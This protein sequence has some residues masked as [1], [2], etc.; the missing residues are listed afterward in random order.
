MSR[1]KVSSLLVVPFSLLFSACGGPTPTVISGTLLGHDGEPMMAAA[2]RVSRW[3]TRDQRDSTDPGAVFQEVDNGSFTIETFETGLL[4]VRFVGAYH[5]DHDVALYADTP[6]STELDVRLGT[7]EYPRTFEKVKLRGVFND[8]GRLDAVDMERQP[9]GSYSAE[10]EVNDDEVR[11]WLDATNDGGHTYLHCT[12]SDEFFYDQGYESVG[13]PV[14]GVLSV[15]FDP[16]KMPHEDRDAEVRFQDPESLTA[17]IAVNLERAA[18]RVRDYETAEDESEDEEFAYDWTNDISELKAEL[19]AERDSLI[20]QTLYLDLLQ[21]KYNHGDV[22]RSL[23]ASALDEIDP[24]AS[25]WSFEPGMI[26]TAVEYVARPDST[27]EGRLSYERVLAVIDS[28]R[29]FPSG[30][31]R[32][33]YILR[34]LDEHPDGHVPA[35]MLSYL[36]FYADERDD[37]AMVNH[38]YGRL[39][40]EHPDYPDLAFLSSIYAPERN[41]A[42]GREIP[43]FSVASLEDSTVFHSRDDLLGNVYLIDFWATWCAPCVAEL[44]NVHEAYERF[45]ER[46]FQVLSVALN[47]KRADI[48]DFRRDQQPMPWLHAFHGWEDDAVKAFE[49]VAIPR[50][51]L[52]GAD[53]IILASDVDC[54]GDR[55]HE[56]LERVLGEGN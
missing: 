53:G 16:S 12:D 39:A 3:S 41:I 9:N 17:R 50:A 13:Q 6:V 22:A 7:R 42:A 48:A 11:Y 51:I 19:A 32:G 52:V 47:D 35:E 31:A 40:T 25:I 54:R 2:V 18:D 55:L 43:D 1:F 28:A 15:E 10:V 36:L 4:A 33:G 46:G 20:R 45:K 37:T 34:A 49:V 27:R 24:T 56:T 5:E 14:D 23:V 29:R 30:D 8:D 26:L 21:I 38:Y 44:P